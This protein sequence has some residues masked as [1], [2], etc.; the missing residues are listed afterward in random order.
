M[1]QGGW[2]GVKDIS[3]EGL[4]WDRSCP[5]V[6]GEAVQPPASPL[7][8]FLTNKPFFQLP[9][10]SKTHALNHNRRS[11]ECSRSKTKASRSPRITPAQM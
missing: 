9:P 10:Q 2:S 4:R 8:Q 5:Q 3:Q 11:L 1:L 6:L 7:S